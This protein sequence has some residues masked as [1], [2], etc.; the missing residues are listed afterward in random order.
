MAK[1]DFLKKD[2]HNVWELEKIKEVALSAPVCKTVSDILSHYPK[3]SSVLDAGSGLGKWVFYCQ[4]KGYQGYGIDIVPKAVERCLRYASRQGLGCCFSAGDIRSMPFSDNSFE[5]VMSF[6]AIE[7]FSDSIKALEE[8]YRVLKKGGTCL[9]TVPNIYSVRTFFTRPL[10]NILKSP[11]LGYQ[12]RE[13]SFSPSRLCG[14]MKKA[15][16]NNFEC[17]IMPDGDLLGECYKF[18]PLI[19]GPLFSLSRRISFW[20][21]RRQSK[22]GHTSYC[23]GKK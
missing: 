15:G 5:V 19:G 8:F 3:G 11:K 21:E 4:R 20:I 7:H 1:N 17:G 14:M 6:G 22:L 13:K 16:F 18:I 23:I 9:V 12:G 10:L 2:W